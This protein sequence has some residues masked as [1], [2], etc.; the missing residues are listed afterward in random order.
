MITTFQKELS[1]DRAP[2]CVRL[3][4]QDTS[5]HTHLLQGVSTDQVEDKD[6]VFES[7][8]QGYA[9]SLYPQN[10]CF[11]SEESISFGGRVLIITIAITS[12]IKIT[13]IIVIFNIR[14]ISQESQKYSLP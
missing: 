11:W 13:G 9:P 12:V 8:I 1:G 7:Q 5:L 2:T 3:E 10:K 6:R 14:R 4:K